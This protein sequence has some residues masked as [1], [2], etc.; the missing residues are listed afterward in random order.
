MASSSSE[1]N[2][3]SS[4]FGG[5]S[6]PARGNNI[7]PGSFLN[8]STR[9]DPAPVKVSV[10]HG[11]GSDT[12]AG[13][14]QRLAQEF[15][16][17]TRAYDLEN[18][19]NNSIHAVLVTKTLEGSKK[20]EDVNSIRVTLGSTLQESE[21]LELDVQHRAK[22]ASRVPLAACRV[23]HAALA[24]CRMPRLPRAACRVPR[25]ACRVPRTACRV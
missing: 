9:A 23:P 24:A 21:E 10:P 20:H 18:D 3:E 14:K 15:S 16:E 12:A 25:A 17:Q 19:G 1:E 7:N 5:G 6:A 11:G 13:V 2:D 4:Y 8:G 22:G